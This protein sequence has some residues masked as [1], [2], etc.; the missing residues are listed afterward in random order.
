MRRLSYFVLVL[1]LGAAGPN[2]IGVKPGNDPFAGEPEFL[3]VDQAFV[4]SARLQGGRLVGRW[5]MPDSYYLYRR[6]F[7]IEAGDGVR[8]G[9]VDMPAGRQIVDDVFGES[10]VYYGSVEISAAVLEHAG[11]EVVASFRYQ[12]CADYGLCYPPQT[13]PVRLAVPQDEA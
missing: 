9:E 8:L 6:Q 13:R 1:L 3:A 4:F 7:R 5:E 12:G 10:E 2:A 11:A